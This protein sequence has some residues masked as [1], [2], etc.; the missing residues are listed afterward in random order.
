MLARQVG[1]FEEKPDVGVSRHLD[2]ASVVVAKS[3]G[4]SSVLEALVIPLSS[5]W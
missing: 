3:V 4:A 2:M 1:S 5:A